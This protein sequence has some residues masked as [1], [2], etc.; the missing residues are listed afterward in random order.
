MNAYRFRKF[1]GTAPPPGGHP[2][3]AAIC[4]AACTDIPMTTPSSAR[5]AYRFLRQHCGGGSVF[6]IPAPD[7]TI[8]R[9]HGIRRTMPWSFSSTTFQRA[10]QWRSWS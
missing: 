6:A 9:S 10:L 3:Y 2:A 8:S 4:A 7:H 1:P 5:L